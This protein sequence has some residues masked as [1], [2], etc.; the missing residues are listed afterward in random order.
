ALKLTKN[1]SAPGI[2]GALYELWKAICQQCDKDKG[3]EGKETF[4]IIELMTEAFNDIS[5]HGI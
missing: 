4:D 1:H 2:D 3:D 5:I